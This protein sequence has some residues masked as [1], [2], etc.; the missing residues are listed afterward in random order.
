MWPWVMM[1]FVGFLTIFILGSIN[2]MFSNPIQPNIIW[3]F[4]NTILP[5]P[6]VDGALFVNVCFWVGDEFIELKK[7]KKLHSYR[8]PLC[9]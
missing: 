5:R 8:L 7:Q 2:N 3:Q 6:C 4:A 9:P 1:A